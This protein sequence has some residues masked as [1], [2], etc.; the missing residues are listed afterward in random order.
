MDLDYYIIKKTGFYLKHEEQLVPTSIFQ[1]TPAGLKMLCRHYSRKYSIDLRCVDLRDDV[2]SGDNIRYF[3][4]YLRSA[5]HLLDLAE[6]QARGLVLSHGQHHVVPVLIIKK[7]DIKYMF[8]FDSS[9][10]SRVRGYFSLANIFIDYQFYLNLG[11]RQADEGSC[12]TDAICILKEALMIPEFTDLVASKQITEHESFAPGRFFT[13]PKPDNFYLFKMPE[14]LLL[15]AQITR[16]LEQSDAD[17]SVILRGGRSLREYRDDFLLPV[18][19]DKNETSSITPINGYL[20]LKSEEH[21]KILDDY[22][23]LAPLD[24]PEDLCK[25]NHSTFS[26]D[27]DCNDNSPYPNFG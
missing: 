5:T 6:G 1:P 24:L 27:A 21:K 26:E 14:K 18:I 3:F 25:S 19:L 2:I 15:T 8:V 11:T 17:E 13:C 10:G 4:E 23:V 16:Y 9:S 12:M 20:Y 22:A 7:N